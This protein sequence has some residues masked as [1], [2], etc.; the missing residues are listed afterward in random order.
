[1]AEMI[2]DVNGDWDSDGERRKALE[3]REGRTRGRRLS[4]ERSEH[5]EGA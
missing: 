3:P 1:M 2:G 5:A 4:D